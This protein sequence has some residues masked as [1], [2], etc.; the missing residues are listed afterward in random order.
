MS[1][2]AVRDSLGGP[3]PRRGAPGSRSERR[4]AARGF[5]AP[6][7]R[8]A[9]VVVRLHVPPVMKCGTHAGAEQRRRL[10]ALG[11]SPGGAL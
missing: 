1:K 4:L 9:H 11:S 6:T 5:E 8:N 3:R 7:G 2:N 10:G